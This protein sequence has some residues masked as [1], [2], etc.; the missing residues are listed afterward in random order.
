MDRDGGT[1]FRPKESFLADVEVLAPTPKKFPRFRRLNC[2]GIPQD[3]ALTKFF[4]SDRNEDVTP[5]PPTVRSVPVESE[6]RHIKPFGIE[7]QLIKRLFGVR[8]NQIALD[9]LSGVWLYSPDNPD[10]A[11]NFLPMKSVP[12]NDVIRLRAD[13][14]ISLA[15]LIDPESVKPTVKHHS[16]PDYSLEGYCV[17][18]VFIA[19]KQRPLEFVLRAENGAV[20]G[21]NIY[22]A[23]NTSEGFIIDL[24]KSLDLTR[25]G[26]KKMLIWIS[27]LAGLDHP[28]TRSRS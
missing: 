8:Y 15:N 25:G 3:A 26:L 6:G 22:F 1:Y 18:G 11:Y 9:V 24:E 7:D 20:S 13:L 17:H 14:V 12:P 28:I 2:E 5:Q 19:G 16:D 21:I 10:V 23:D 27:S 4:N